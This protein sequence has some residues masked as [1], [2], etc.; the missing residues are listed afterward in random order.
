MELRSPELVI[1]GFRVPQPDPVLL[2]KL[3][4]LKMH[5]LTLFVKNVDVLARTHDE[6]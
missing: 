2:A 5:E 1:E 4:L 3:Q 6:S